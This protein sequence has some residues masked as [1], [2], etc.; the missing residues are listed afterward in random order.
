MSLSTKQRKELRAKA[1]DL[2]PVI[3]VGQK[4]ISENLLLE[5][6]RALDTHELIKVHI[7]QNDREAR[8]QCMQELASRSE[9]EL[10]GQ[11]GKICILYRRNPDA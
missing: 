5:T 1:H 10:V 3:R 7:A 9:A 4:G 6:S 2:K 11:I 8:K